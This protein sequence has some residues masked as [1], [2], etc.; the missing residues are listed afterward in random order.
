MRRPGVELIANGRWATMRVAWEVIAVGLVGAVIGWRFSAWHWK[1]SGVDFGP[2]AWNF[3]D[4][5]PV[6]PPGGED[7]PEDADAPDQGDADLVGQVERQQLEPEVDEPDQDDV[8]DGED[9]DHARASG[10]A[11]VVG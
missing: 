2:T 7:Q 8:G 11:A 6:K 1:H 5:N 3:A 9:D 10:V 4:A